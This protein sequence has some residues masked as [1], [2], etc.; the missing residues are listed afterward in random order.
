MPPT[1][2]RHISQTSR[3][4]ERLQIVIVIEDPDIFGLQLAGKLLGFLQLQRVGFF[5]VF[6]SANIN[7]SI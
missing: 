7:I 5:Y 6:M 1:Q 3:R 2:R 4:R